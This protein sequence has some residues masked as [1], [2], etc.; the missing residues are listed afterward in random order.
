MSH[1]IIVVFSNSLC[2]NNV[3]YLYFTYLDWDQVSDV[4]LVTA[5]FR[6]ISLIRHWQWLL[7]WEWYKVL[8]IKIAVESNDYSVD[9]TIN[10]SFRFK[11]RY[12]LKEM[13]FVEWVSEKARNSPCC[14]MCFQNLLA[15]GMGQYNRAQSR[16]FHFVYVVDLVLTREFD[17]F[18]GTHIDR[19]GG[20]PRHPAV[21][22]G[23]SSGTLYYRHHARRP[24]CTD[25]SK[26]H[27][28]MYFN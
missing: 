28:V 24:G 26:E 22:H 20:F 17:S 23:N 8:G 11:G 14:S 6:P 18:V 27:Q 2:L 10:C 21:W 12:S 7:P 13:E 19:L 5:V 9:I 16:R 1:K 25:P 15:K 4:A 3:L